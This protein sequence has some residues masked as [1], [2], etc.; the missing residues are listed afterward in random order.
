[1]L[2][3]SAVS[4]TSRTDA[5]PG[6]AR[7][8]LH[9]AQARLAYLVDLRRG[10]GLVSGGTADDCSAIAEW[11]A[12]TFA[13]QGHEVVT[14][15]PADADRGRPIDALAEGLHLP[16]HESQPA[17]RAWHALHHHLAQNISCR[18]TTVVIAHAVDSNDATFIDDL[19]Q[20]V[21]LATLLETRLI[22]IVIC[23]PH[24]GPGVRRSF[25]IWVD[26]EIP[27]RTGMG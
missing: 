26:L 1:M 21:H 16:V 20:L 23:Q 11:A 12:G 10:L 6:R 3:P 13:A 4:T 27:L 24:H 8:W 14:V 15:S 18:R 17:W 7:S 22:L 9:E 2:Q 19:L 5:R 25:G